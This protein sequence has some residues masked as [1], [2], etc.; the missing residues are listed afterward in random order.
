M[1]HDLCEVI[2]ECRDKKRGLRL[3]IEDKD[4]FNVYGDLLPPA[5]HLNQ[6]P[7]QSLAEFI[8]SGAFRSMTYQNYQQ[9]LEGDF[10]NTK[11]KRALALRLGRC[12]MD[13]FD[14]KHTLHTWDPSKIFFLV[15]HGIQ[16]TDKLLYM[17]FLRN[18]SDF[19]AA[20]FELGD[21]V[22]LSFAKLLLEIDSG[23]KMDIELSPQREKNVEKWFEL[24]QMADKEQGSYWDAVNGC[25][26]IHSHITG[27][28]DTDVGMRQVI[29]ER[30]VK[31]LEIESNPPTA[32]SQK[33]YRSDSASESDYLDSTFLAT[34]Q[35]LS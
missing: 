23:Q 17:S 21:P 16:S 13:F 19:P 10:F 5:M 8:E 15:Q 11:Q 34:S 26:Y 12:L 29:Y 14:Y 4:I 32:R 18:E 27:D 9:R 6:L 20:S 1:I 31:H 35:K 25:L 3:H 7:A 22:I 28:I 2:L 30:I 24:V 33:R